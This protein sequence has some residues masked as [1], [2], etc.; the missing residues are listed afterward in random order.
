MSVWNKYF[1]A[2]FRNREIKLCNKA[3]R[4]RQRR[5]DRDCRETYAFYEIINPAVFSPQKPGLCPSSRCFFGGSLRN[6]FFPV[7]SLWNLIGHQWDWILG[8]I[9]SQCAYFLSPRRHGIAFMRLSIF[10]KDYFQDD[11]EPWHAAIFYYHLGPFVT[12]Y[13]QELTIN[14]NCLNLS[15]RAA[16]WV[17]GLLKRSIYRRRSSAAVVQRLQSRNSVKISLHCKKYSYEF[18]STCTESFYA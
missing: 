18:E 9:G 12:K 17:D 4:Q 13:W 15:S 8:T 16:G 10:I 11:G 5:K 1:N 7:S 2:E 14:S 6:S 3:R